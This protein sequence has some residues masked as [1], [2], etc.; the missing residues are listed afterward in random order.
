MSLTPYQRMEKLYL[1]EPEG[2]TLEWYVM[3]HLRNGW[4]VS[5]NADYFVMGKPVVS[6]APAELFAKPEHVF[7]IEQCDAWYVSAMA[8]DM[9]KAWAA[10]PYPLPLMCYHRGQGGSRG[11]RFVR[12][13]ANRRFTKGKP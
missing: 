10:M 9:A 6:T 7:P 8:G 11:L 13:D 3:L 5:A 1:D 2:Q 12:T 4:V